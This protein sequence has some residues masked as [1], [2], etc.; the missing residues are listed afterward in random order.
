MSFNRDINKL[1]TEVYFSQRR[2][3]SLSPPIIFN[4]N[5]VLTSPCQ[6][7]L[8]I[9]LDSTLSFNK[10]ITQKMNKATAVTAAPRNSPH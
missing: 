3:K 2:K 1:E 5:N 6:K 8:G 9:V 10:L 4:S 7:Y